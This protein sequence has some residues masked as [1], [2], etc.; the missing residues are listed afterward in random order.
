MADKREHSL[1]LIILQDLIREQKTEID[2]LQTV[3]T[4]FVDVMDI[5]SMRF[6]LTIK[7]VADLLNPVGDAARAALKGKSNGR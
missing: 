2:K 5:L 7:D 1:N 6:G 4:D 3:L